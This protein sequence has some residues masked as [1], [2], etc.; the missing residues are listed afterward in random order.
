MATVNDYRQVVHAVLRP[1]AEA[2]YSNVEATNKLICA[3]NDGQYLILSIG[4][5]KQPKRR[6]HGCLIHI[7]ILDGKIWIQRD[8]TE[9][10]IA[11][12]LEDAGVPKE[13]IV[14]GFHDP[15][16]RVHTGYAAP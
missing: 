15:R 10:G 1:Y 7:E 4:W 9:D 12:E 5:A 14:L 16:L 2:K 13:D 6:I 3:E 8:G 11:G